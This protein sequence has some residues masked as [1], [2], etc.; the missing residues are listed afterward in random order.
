MYKIFDME[1]IKFIIISTFVILSFNSSAS[2]TDKN[3]TNIYNVS[4]VQ[5]ISNPA[6]YHGK[7]ILVSG[8]Y[9][10]NNGLSALFLTQE[11][12]KYIDTS[13]AIWIPVNQITSKGCKNE[14]I[15]ES[16]FISSPEDAGGKFITVF[17]Y[18]DME[19]RGDLGFFQ[20]T[21]ENVKCFRYYGEP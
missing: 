15:Y 11:H 12:A 10:Y 1:K 7:A 13:N 6:K 20:G 4:L 17:G 2:Y 16:S 19:K 18:Y 21:I 14:P 3:S 9:E 5:L 8:F